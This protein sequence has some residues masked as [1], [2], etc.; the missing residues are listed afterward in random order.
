VIG[1]DGLHSRV[2]GLARNSM[3]GRFRGLANSAASQ[4]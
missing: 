4:V 3:C 2:R 1:A